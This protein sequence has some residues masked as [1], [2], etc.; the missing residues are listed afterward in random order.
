VLELTTASRRQIQ[1]DKFAWYA[2]MLTARKS[3][4]AVAVL[5]YGSAIS[6]MVPRQMTKLSFNVGGRLLDAKPMLHD[7]LPL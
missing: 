2:S 7:Y 4:A 5:Q 3:L 6:I 1:D